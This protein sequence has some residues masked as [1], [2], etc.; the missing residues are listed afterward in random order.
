MKQLIEVTTLRI[1]TVMQAIC[2]NVDF[3]VV[4]LPGGSLIAILLSLYSIAMS[5][6]RRAGWILQLPLIRLRFRHHMYKGGQLIAVH[7]RL[8]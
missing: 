3:E 6:S 5:F 7:S 2:T 8:I 1:G 4:S